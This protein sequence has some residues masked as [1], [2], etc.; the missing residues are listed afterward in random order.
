[1]KNNPH[2]KKMIFVPNITNME[3]TIDI[4]ISYAISYVISSY[5]DVF[6][7]LND[8]VA[9]MENV[10]VEK[11]AHIA[12]L[13]QENANLKDELETVKMTAHLAELANLESLASIENVLQNTKA[14]VLR[15]ARRTLCK[16]QKN[17]TITRNYG[18][19]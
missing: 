15:I 1:M 5:G 6:Q 3:L 10:I 13:A 17:K 4:A 7:T 9:Q 8:Q 16:D 11:D 14:Q 18:S 19:L 12:W 2:F